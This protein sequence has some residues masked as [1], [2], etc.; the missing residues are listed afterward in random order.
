VADHG[1]HAR[2]V[3]DDALHATA[4]AVRLCRAADAD[5]TADD[6]MLDLAALHPEA[7]PEDLLRAAGY[8]ARLLSD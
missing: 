8:A 5:A 6:V 2:D 3:P 7:A 1:I 4:D